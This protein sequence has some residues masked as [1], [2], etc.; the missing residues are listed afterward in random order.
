MADPSTFLARTRLGY[1]FSGFGGK[2]FVMADSDEVRS[3]L[4]SCK[5]SVPI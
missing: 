4:S 1:G 5:D 3:V 2:A